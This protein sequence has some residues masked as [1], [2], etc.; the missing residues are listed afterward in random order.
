MPNDQIGQAVIWFVGTLVIEPLRGLV[1][2]LLAE[3]LCEFRQAAGLT[4]ICV[5]LDGIVRRPTRSA[6]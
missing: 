5:L 2:H 3:G 4:A 6:T 1:C